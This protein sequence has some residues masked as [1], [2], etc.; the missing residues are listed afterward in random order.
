MGQDYPEHRHETYSPTTLSDRLS[1]DGPCATLVL[2][3]DEML[4]PGAL[5]AL[6]FEMAHRG[7]LAVAG[8]RVLYEKAVNGL[9]VPALT[10]HPDAIGG[11]ILWAP[12]ALKGDADLEA[13]WASLPAEAKIRIGRPVVLRRGQAGRSRSLLPSSP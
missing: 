6:A 10:G 9:D 13:A 3:E 11:E 8:L 12:G 5:A 4:A 7:A 2:R 1:E